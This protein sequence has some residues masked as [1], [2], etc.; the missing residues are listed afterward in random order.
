M[1][2]NGNF[3]VESTPSQAF[4]FITDAVKMSSVIPDVQEFEVIDADSYRLK[5]KVGLSFI[6][7][8]F[9]LR[10]RIENKIP[11]KHAELSGSGTGSGSS[12]TFR[13]ICDISE[14]APGSTRIVWS[15]DVEIGGLA[16]SV[17]SRLVQGAS[18]KY[19]NQLIDTFRN[20]LSSE[21]KSALQ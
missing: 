5:L 19:I 3:L 4:S 14:V 15:A 13:G 20:A 18:E 10:V 17:G 11:D 7:G 9:N 8:K 16:A 6:K 12:A 2:F 1:K 21:G